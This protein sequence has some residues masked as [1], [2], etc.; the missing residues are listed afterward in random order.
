MSRGLISRDSKIKM[1]LKIDEEWIR[2]R[3]HL[4]HDNLGKL[5]KNVVIFV[6][7]FSNSYFLSLIA[8]YHL[9]AQWADMRDD[10]QL[11][12]DL[13]LV[14]NCIFRRILFSTST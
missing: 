3:V 8:H 2:E 7:C 12:F 9:I 10:V 1:A 11:Y 5:L 13:R 14:Y 6:L 4:Q